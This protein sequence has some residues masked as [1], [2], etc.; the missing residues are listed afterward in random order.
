MAIGVLAHGAWSAAWA[1]LS[2][3]MSCYTQ[4]FRYVS[5]RRN[6]R[7]ANLASPMKGRG[8]PA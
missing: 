3:H 5:A 1:S 4:V 7:K 8:S 2:S 6:Q